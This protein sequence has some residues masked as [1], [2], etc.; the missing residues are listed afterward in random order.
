M[1]ID[2][3]SSDNRYRRRRLDD[4]AEILD[5]AGLSVPR[6]ALDAAYEASG[7]YLGRVWQEHRDVPVDRHVSSILAAAD[8][9][10]PRRVAPRVMA[11][12][13]QAYGRPALLVPPAVDPGAR[14]ALE[15][16]AARGYTLAVISNTMRTPGVVL[17]QLL[18]H[19][20]L[21]TFFAHTAFS[22]EVGVRKPAAEIFA[23]SLRAVGGEP[24][25]AV[26]VGDDPILDVEGAHGAGMRAVHL[27]STPGE[28]PAG[29]A[30][31]AV[32]R[33]IRDLPE[34]VARLDVA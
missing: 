14:A 7:G 20:G 5:T 22:D 4:F 15:A 19:Y 13:V 29:Q 8:P 6:R 23:R 17:R 9:A 10:L 24:A 28:P 33:S 32:I 26:H 3:P 12:L 25:T 16:L 30:A 18:G 34:A 21:L 11:E 27:R 1:L 31:D 2:P